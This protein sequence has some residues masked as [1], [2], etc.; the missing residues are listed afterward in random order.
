MGL[1]DL[2]AVLIRQDQNR[3]NFYFITGV[4]VFRAENAASF[5]RLLNV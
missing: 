2:P 5:I 4:Q 3:A 1:I